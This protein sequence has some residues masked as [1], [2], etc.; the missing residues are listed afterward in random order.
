MN[1]NVIQATFNDESVI[2]LNY[3]TKNLLFIDKQGKETKTSYQEASTG[4]N[5][6]L[7]KRLKY[8]EESLKHIW[9]A[10]QN[11]LMTARTSRNHMGF[12]PE[13]LEV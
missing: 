6:D 9:N 13:K 5:K 7:L 2:V 10:Q 11:N 1:T 12:E 4:D 8:V 3:Q